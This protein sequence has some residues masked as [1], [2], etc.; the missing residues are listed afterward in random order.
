MEGRVMWEGRVALIVQTTSGPK[1]VSGTFKF[2][3]VPVW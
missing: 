2:G 3:I 1:P